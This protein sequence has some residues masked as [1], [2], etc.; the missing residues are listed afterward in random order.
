[1]EPWPDKK[2][3][4]IKYMAYQPFNG[5]TTSHGAEAQELNILYKQE[6]ATQAAC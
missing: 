5:S 3:H 2:S 4:I 1:M 6:M